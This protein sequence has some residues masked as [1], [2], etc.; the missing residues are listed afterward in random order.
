MGS[1]DHS[2]GFMDIEAGKLVGN[3]KGASDHPINIVK[4]YDR[5]TIVTGDDGGM[6][7]VSTS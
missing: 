7:S 5:S 1:A 6:V 3:L 2:L 4:V